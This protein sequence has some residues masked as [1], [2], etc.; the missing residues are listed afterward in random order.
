M[1]HVSM[2]ILLMETKVKIERS[3][4]LFPFNIP[5]LKDNFLETTGMNE[6]QWEVI[7]NAPPIK[8]NK[9]LENLIDVLYQ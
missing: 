1:T 6:K 4:K 3:K 7:Y 9:D 8:E 5:K 2:Y